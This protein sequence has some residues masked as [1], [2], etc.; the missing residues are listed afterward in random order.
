MDIQ[1]DVS[2][3][4]KWITAQDTTVANSPQQLGECPS[5]GAAARRTFSDAGH[6]LG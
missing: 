1:E 6:A 5:Q 2:A 3:M 4:A